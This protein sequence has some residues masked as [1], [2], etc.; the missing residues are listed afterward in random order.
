MTSRAPIPVSV[1]TGFLGAGKTTLLNRL[2]REP[3]L[4]DALVIVN[5]WGEISLD[6]LL[7]E[8]IDGDVVLLSSGCLCCSLRGDLVDALHDLAARRDAGRIAPFK[9]IVIETSGLAD[10]A[11][12]LNAIMA[13]QELAFRYRFAGIVTLVDAVNGQATLRNIGESA[14]QVA[15]ADRL[16]ITKSDLLIAPDRSAILAALTQALRRMN[17]GAPILDIAAGEFRAVDLIALDPFDGV[18][19]VAAARQWRPF[20][21]IEPAQNAVASDADSSR[22]ERHKPSISAYDLRLSDPVGAPAF[23]LF[24]DL[25]RAA[26]GPRLLRIKGLV[27]LAEHPDEPLVVHGVQHIFHPPRRLKAWPDEDRSTRIV[28][29]ADGLDRASVDIMWAALAGAPRIDTPDMAALAHNPLT[30]SRGGLLA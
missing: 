15:L 16:A 18:D 6:H 7:I 8:K 25:L 11:P 22:A 28:L 2:L 14:H 27:A 9:R 4:D 24:L 10:P 5:E 17:P 1:V 23:A 3:E 12:V 26:L 20:G 13:D 29:I 21:R 30:P 19:D